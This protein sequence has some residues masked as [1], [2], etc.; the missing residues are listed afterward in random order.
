MPIWSQ[1][2]G[3]DSEEKAVDLYIKEMQQEEIYVVV[4]EVGLLLSKKKPFLGASLGRIITNLDTNEKWG[5]EIKS[6]LSKAGMTVEDAWKTK[7]FFLEKLSDGH[8]R[9]KRNHNY[10]IQ[11]QGQLYVAS[12]LGLKGVVFWRGDVSP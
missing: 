10:Y 1:K 11:V 8:V 12:N 4:E 9:L 6:P 2:Y 7:K 5:M 3:I